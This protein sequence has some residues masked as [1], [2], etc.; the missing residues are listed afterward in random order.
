MKLIDLT[1]GQRA[2]VDDEDYADISQFKWF[3]QW[4]RHGKRFY[5]CRTIPYE[6][7]RHC[8]FM[9]RFLLS[10]PKG[11]KRLVDHINLDSLDNRRSN[12]RICTPSENQMNRPIPRN[13]TSGV[14]GVRRT[15]S[16]WVARV[17]LNRKYVHV[18]SFASI[19]E[20]KAAYIRAAAELYGEF[21][22]P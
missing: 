4:D 7:K 13:N 11:D 14:K 16:S 10:L 22:R 18:G 1:Q 6:G 5:A 21:F 19:E 12:L 9:H 3:A 8:V 20:A 17:K 15:R 2:L